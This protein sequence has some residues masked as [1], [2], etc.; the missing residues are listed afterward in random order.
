ML[1]NSFSYGIPIIA[2]TF[3]PEYSSVMY[4]ALPRVFRFPWQKKYIVHERK[5]VWYGII[6]MRKPSA[7]I[8]HPSDYERV[9][10]RLDNP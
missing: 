8:C 4:M 3:V 9:K 7:I 5:R 6:Y 10:A 2:S 1:I